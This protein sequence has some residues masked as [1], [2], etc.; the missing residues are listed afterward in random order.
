[1]AIVIGDA[2]PDIEGESKVRGE[3]Q[4]PCSEVEVI[5]CRSKIYRKG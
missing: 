4:C 5:Y 3:V 2:L 1:M